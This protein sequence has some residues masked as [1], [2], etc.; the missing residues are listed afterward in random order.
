M[1]KLSCD[2]QLWWAVCATSFELPW[3][4]PLRLLHLATH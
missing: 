3:I 4:P 2:D 1:E